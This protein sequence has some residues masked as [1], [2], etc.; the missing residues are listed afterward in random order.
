MKREAEKQRCNNTVGYTQR[1]LEEQDCDV[2]ILEADGGRGF[3]GLNIR[4]YDPENYRDRE[5]INSLNKSVDKSV[6]NSEFS[7]GYKDQ[8]FCDFSKIHALMGFKTCSPQD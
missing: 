8:S 4:T 2:V 1:T 6:F 5:K 7:S 3:V